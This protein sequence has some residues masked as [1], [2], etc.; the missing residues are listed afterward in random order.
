M[1]L[2]SHLFC[3]FAQNQCKEEIIMEHTGILPSNSL[4]RTTPPLVRPFGKL[5]I[6]HPERRSMKNGMPL[7]VINVGNQE[8]VRLD[9]LVGGGQ[10]HQTLPL[11]AMF[12][13]RML[14]E[15]AG[16][17]SSDEISRKLDYYGAWIECYSSQKCNHIVLY[18]LSKHFEPLLTLLETIVKEPLF[19]EDNL[20]VV[21]RNGKAHFEVNSKKVDILAQRHFEHALWGENHPLGH[22][23]ETADYDNITRD[24]LL[25]YHQKVYNNGNLALFVSGDVSEVEIS[26]VENV[27]GNGE[28]GGECK[29]RDV[30]V[31]YCLSKPGRC[32]IRVEG[33][34]QSAVKIGFMAMDVSNPDFHKFRFLTVLLGGYFGSRLMSNIREE[35][36]YTYHISAEVDAYGK[37]NAFMISSETANE[38]VEPCIKEIY[39]E[40]ERVCNE[41]ISESEVEHVRNYILGE[42]CR[43]CEGLTAKSE[44]FVNAW[45][46]GE[47]FASVNEYLEVV[48]NVTAAE[49]NRVAKEYLKL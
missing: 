32:N 22:I 40:L 20:E 35:N 3:T 44:V 43:E 24:D 26:A 33:T 27:F 16:N 14:R 49:L 47:S 12:T 48:K 9:I 8:V 42:M 17:L 15:G 38:Y 45:L 25:S 11:Q 6:V 29:S 28:W 5:D 30:F 34:V 23:V 37:R 39:K 36:G 19:P 10:W 18:C 31:D 1:V 13:N 46:S 41:P 4:D 7:N 2:S 21:R